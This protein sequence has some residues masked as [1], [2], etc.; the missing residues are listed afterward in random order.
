MVDR[1]ELVH[2]ELVLLVEW[3]ML[4]DIENCRQIRNALVG[5]SQRIEHYNSAHILEYILELQS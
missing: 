1:M 3:H 5:I 2:F 4:S